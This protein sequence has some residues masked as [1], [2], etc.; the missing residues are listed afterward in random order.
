MDYK[1]IAMSELRDYEAKVEAIR[2]L[3]E[4]IKTLNSQI[5]GIHSA[6]S[7]G[8]PVQGGGNQREEMLCNNIALRDQLAANLDVVTGQVAS[9]ERGLNRLDAKHRRILELFYIRREYGYLQRLCNEFNESEREVYRDKDDA[10][11]QY[12]ISRYGVIDI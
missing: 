9:I 3:T 6:T 8:T 7:D 1:R 5:D 12:T 10:L 4:R 2:S 11:R